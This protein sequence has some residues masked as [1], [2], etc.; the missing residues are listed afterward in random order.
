VTNPYDPAQNIMGGTRYLA[1]LMRL[2]GGR[3]D[4][5]LAGYNAG[6][7]AVMKYGRRIPPYAETQ[8]YV[9]IIGTR[10]TQNTGVSLTGKTTARKAP[11]KAK[12]KAKTPTQTKTQT[13]TPTPTQQTPTQAQGGQ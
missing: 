11:A 4:L 13:Q 7:G 6:E 8:I 9:R 10:Y 12:V 3:V 1:L 2:F 5:A